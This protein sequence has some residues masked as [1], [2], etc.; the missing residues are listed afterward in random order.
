[1]I[2]FYCLP[3]KGSTPWIQE[4]CRH[5]PISEISF[6]MRAMGHYPSE[7]EVEDMMNEVKFS[8]YVDTG[9][10]VDS[11]D[12]GDFIKLYVNH[13]PAFGLSL[14]QLHRAFEVLGMQ[15][16]T[17]GLPSIDRG[18]LLDLLQ[19]KGEHLTESE[20]AEYITTLLGLNPE[21]GSSEL[22]S[23]EDE[24]SAELIE[25]YLPGRLNAE[26]FSAEVLGFGLLS[27]DGQEVTSQE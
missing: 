2:L 23:Y 9:K 12:L 4:R 19:T 10:Y 11:I 22:G 26:H 21:G 7:Q 8:K 6:V 25:E 13:R 18:E 20:L 15:D 5:H 16:E 17:G 14:S 27:A 3:A 1:M 24:G